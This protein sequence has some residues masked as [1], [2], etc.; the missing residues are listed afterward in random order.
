LTTTC[1]TPIAGAAEVL[2]A[3]RPVLAAG[4]PVLAAVRRALAG[5]RGVFFEFVANLRTPQYS[6]WG[7]VGQR[8]NNLVAQ[9]FTTN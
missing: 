9:A 4:R 3:G 7:P 1:V 2:A 8:Q 6:G 5:F